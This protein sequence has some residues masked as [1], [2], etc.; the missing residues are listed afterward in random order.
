M[1]TELPNSRS[2]RLLDIAPGQPAD[3]IKANLL[4]VDDLDEAPDFEALSYV[5]GSSDNPVDIVCDNEVASV[6][7]N[8]SGALIRL[9]YVDKSR[10]VWIDALCLYVDRYQR[11][12]HGNLR[13]G[14]LISEGFRFASR[15]RFYPEISE[16]LLNI[17]VKRYH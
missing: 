1:Y 2:I 12:Y 3:P 4:I 16:Q 10:R 15:I 11:K 6:T 17:L 13:F 5:W 9:R 14:P 7:R 8:L